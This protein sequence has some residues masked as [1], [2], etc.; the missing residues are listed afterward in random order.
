VGVIASSSGGGSNEESR[1]GFQFLRAA[2]TARS[3]GEVFSRRSFRRGRRRTGSR[4]R[5]GPE[6]PNP[7]QK[8]EGGEWGDIGEKGTIGFSDNG[9]CDNH[10]CNRW[11]YVIYR[12]TGCGIVQS[13]KKT[14]FGITQPAP[15]HPGRIICSLQNTPNRLEGRRVGRHRRKRHYQ[16]QTATINNV[17]ITS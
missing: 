6:R 2:A 12:A 15:T 11:L 8:L 14:S 4:L 17:A 16:I 10:C 3:S 9:Q 7:K 13:I 1:L 5:V